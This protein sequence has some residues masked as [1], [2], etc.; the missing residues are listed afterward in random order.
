MEAQKSE[1]DRHD[2]PSCRA[3][4]VRRDLHAIRLRRHS[5]GV[6]SLPRF[7]ALLFY[8]VTMSDWFENT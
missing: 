7:K 2:V 4:I 1:S 5:N 3:V 6:L 8:R